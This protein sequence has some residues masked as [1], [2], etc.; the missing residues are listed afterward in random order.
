M[1]HAIRPWVKP[2]PRIPALAVSVKLLLAE[3]NFAEPAKPL[4]LVRKIA[5][6]VV[7]KR[8]LRQLIVVRRLAS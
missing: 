4:F 1:E 8:E 5:P 7:W 6:V 3:M 2:V